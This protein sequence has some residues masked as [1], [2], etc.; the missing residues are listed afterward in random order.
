METMKLGGWSDS[1]TMRKIYTHL[2]DKDR[3][4]ASNKMLDFYKKANEN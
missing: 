3:L 1:Q 4:A 2:S